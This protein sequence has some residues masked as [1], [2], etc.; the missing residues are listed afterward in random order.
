[1][2]FTPRG[3]HVARALA[4]DERE[5]SLALEDG[6]GDIGQHHGF[7]VADDAARRLVEGVDR[8]GLL[9]RAVFHVVD[10]HA[11]HVDRLRQGRAQLHLCHRH[12]FAVG[13]G[14]LQGAAIFGEARNQ[15]VHQVARPG[16]RDLAHHRGHIDDRVSLENAQTEIIEVDEFHKRV[17]WRT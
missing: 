16:V 2:K 14:P 13:G 1:M 4:D 3:R 7:A 17:L 9:A 12:A 11:V 10:G 5:L 15:A 8:R 6:R